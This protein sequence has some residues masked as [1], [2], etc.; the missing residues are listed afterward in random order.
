MMRAHASVDGDTL[1]DPDGP[2]SYI[3]AMTRIVAVNPVLPMC[4]YPQE[5]ITEVF[6]EVC[7]PP[8]GRQELLRRLHAGARVGHRHLA[9]PLDDYRTLDDFGK[10]NDAFI[11]VGTELGA[12]AVDGALKAAGLEPADVDLIIS[13]TVTG[14]AIPSLDARVAAEIG[15]RP[16]VKRV[17]MLGLGCLAGAAGIARLH[18]YLRAIRIRSRC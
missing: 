11:R 1:A 15:L 10:A 12:R 13:T 8:D 4:S 7:L 6:A 17:P 3:G 18:D 9:L 2:L 16:D 14:I 5:Q